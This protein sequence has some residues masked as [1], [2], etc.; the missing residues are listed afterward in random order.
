V[1]IIAPRPDY[2]WSDEMSEADNVGQLIQIMD[3]TEDRWGDYIY[4][5][6]S[7]AHWVLTFVNENTWKV[8]L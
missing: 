3:E 1:T 5:Y 7:M 4:D 6:Y 2:T 8:G